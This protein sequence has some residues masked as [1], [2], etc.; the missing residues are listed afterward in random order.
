MVGT[1]SFEDETWNDVPLKFEAG[2][3]AFVE[4]IGLGAAV[5]YLDRRG[6]T[7]S[8]STSAPWSPMPSIS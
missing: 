3:P 6:W 1:V 8:A 4:A 5:E 7:P 2:T